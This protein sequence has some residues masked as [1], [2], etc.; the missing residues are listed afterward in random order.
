MEPRYMHPSIFIFFFFHQR[1][2]TRH[3]SLIEFSV[4]SFPS[5]CFFSSFLNRR[6]RVKER[7]F[8]R[9]LTGTE[10]EIER[11]IAYRQ[12]TAHPPCIFYLSSLYLEFLSLGLF[13]YLSIFCRSWIQLL[14][15]LVCKS[16]LIFDITIYLCSA[17][18]SECSYLP[19]LCIYVS[20][21]Y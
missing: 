8:H 1:T 4:P 9:K 13:T 11:R 15:S 2:V 20:F 21:T 10:R 6:W 17:S 16:L 3:A 5:S 19:G 12:K 18:L 7:E 14:S